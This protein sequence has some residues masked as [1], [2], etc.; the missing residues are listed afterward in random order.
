MIIV[1]GQK[2]DGLQQLLGLEFTEEANANA[3]HSDVKLFKVHCFVPN[4]LTLG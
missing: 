3:W 2:F 1:G 4:T